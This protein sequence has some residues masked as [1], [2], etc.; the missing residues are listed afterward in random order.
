MRREHKRVAQ[1]G[2]FQRRNST[3]F[4][5][6]RKFKKGNN[7]SDRE[8]GYVIFYVW[9]NVDS[10]KRK[11]VRP[12]FVG[13]RGTGDPGPEG[14][15]IDLF[16]RKE[17]EETPRGRAGSYRK[18]EKTFEG[19]TRCNTTVVKGEAEKDGGKKLHVKGKKGGSALESVCH[20]GGKG[21]R[22][23]SR[24]HKTGMFG[25]NPGKQMKE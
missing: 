15:T 23:N 5:K 18:G 20:Q 14:I 1:V 25:G 6:V 8:C 13:I 12:P 21:K 10:E 11:G 7:L 24:K 2:K 17:G 9:G 19:K 3:H 4:R 16:I 22:R